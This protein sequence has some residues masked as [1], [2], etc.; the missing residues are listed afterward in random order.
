MNF[1]PIKKIP[2][3]KFESKHRLTSELNSTYPE[4]EAEIPKKGKNFK[5]AQ[6]VPFDTE[7]NKEILHTPMIS[8]YPQTGMEEQTNQSFDS[9][10][11]Y[12]LRSNTQRKGANHSSYLHG[13]NEKIDL[14]RKRICKTD[15]P[16][17][18]V[19]RLN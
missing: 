17:S 8:E 4:I 19:Q 10:H 16:K 7:P 2:K 14:K 3:K 12:V 5:I 9:L 18:K 13:S 6:Y 11:S 15:Q 1:K